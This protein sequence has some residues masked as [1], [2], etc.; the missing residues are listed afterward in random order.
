MKKAVH[1]SAAAL[2]KSSAMQLTF[3]DKHPEVER[4]PTE[5]ALRGN[6]S[7]SCY[8][9]GPYVEMRGTHRHGSALLH[10]A[11]DNVLDNGNN[12]VLRE[13]K[14]VEGDYE[15]WYF[16][17]SVIQTAFYGELCA[18]VKMLQTADFAKKEGAPVHKLLIDKPLLS[19]LVFG[20]DDYMVFSN[21]K[22]SKFYF[23]KLNCVGD[24]KLSK[25]WDE[26]HKHKD[27]ERLADQITIKPI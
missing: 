26:K 3:R 12:Y 18:M 14:S 23:E 27:W 1:F 2:V 4:Q 6:F 11:I 8:S 17:M 22:V 24:W 21:G 16:H 13:L 9:V 10:F 5:R 7:A 15:E 19:Q 25:A 20:M